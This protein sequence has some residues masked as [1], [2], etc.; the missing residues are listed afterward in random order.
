MSRVPD[1]P[2]AEMSSEQQ[3]LY[4][5]IS[6]PR[7]NVAG[8]FA[9]WI[10]LPAVA[11]VANKFGNALRLEGKLDRRIFELVVLIIARHWGAQYE[12]FVHEPAAIKAGL[13]PEI[14][15]AI[16][17][18]LEPAYA[19]DD[20]RVAATLTKELLQSRAVSLAT[21]DRTLDLFGLD[22]VI[23]MITVIGFYTT[24]AMMIN[25]FESS[26]PGDARPLPALEEGG[27]LA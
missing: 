21:Y 11:D 8:P 10:R 5:E 27:H 15:A 26:V 7:G 14:A 18:G 22:L 9:L 1:L 12:W 20:E 24:A 25:T 2:A 6:G 3:R 4:Q 16:R 19:R 23:E 17:N 13:A